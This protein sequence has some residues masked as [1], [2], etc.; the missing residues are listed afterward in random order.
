MDLEQLKT[1][2]PREGTSP[3]KQDEY[4]LSLLGKRSNSPIARMKRNLRFELVAIIILYG[5]STIYY[6]FAFDGKMSELSWIML[7]IGLLFIP[8]YYRKNK[9]LNEMQCVSCQV[10]SHLSRQLKTLEK[11]VRFYLISGSVLVPL[12]ML[13]AGYVS[14]ILYP[15]KI[16]T[17]KLLPDTPGGQQFIYF[18]LLFVL[19]FSVAAHFANKW[20]VHK[21]YGR[22][23]SKLKS[24]VS[25]MSD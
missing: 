7:G 12:I 18:F 13:A 22:H 11:Y 3:Q 23:I 8:Y 14:L 21:L 20:Y 1:I 5:A 10:K 2:W 9:L 15:A 6:F 19:V 16:K 17:P 24:I 4:L 25:E